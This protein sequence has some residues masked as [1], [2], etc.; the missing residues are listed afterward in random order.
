MDFLNRKLAAFFKMSEA[1]TPADPTFISRAFHGDQ[2]CQA[3][4]TSICSRLNISS[5]VETGTYLGDTSEYMA[6]VIPVPIYTCEVKESFYDSSADRLRRYT[7]VNVLCESSDRFIRRGIDQ[8]LLGKLPLFYL[9]AHWYDYWP[10]LD[11]I[12]LINAQ[13]PRCVVIID[14]FQVPGRNDF[15]FCAGGGGSPEFSGRTTVDSRLC[16]IDLIRTRLI[17]RSDYRLL[18]PDYQ[19]HQ[20]F[21]N[22][23]THSLVGYVAIFKNLMTEF[24]D[25]TEQQFI[26]N[27]FKIVD[28]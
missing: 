23:Q 15:S 25:L 6:R 26:R 5:F 19:Q 11:E 12:E 14:D 9:D 1:A 18:Y 3:F 22:S 4:V 27:N 8:N 16:N 28:L 13:V 17:N 21:G 10:L 20:A 7:H 2:L 24:T